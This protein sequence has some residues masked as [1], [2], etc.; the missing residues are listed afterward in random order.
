MWLSINTTP[1][2]FIEKHLI[3]KIKYKT[4]ISS[5]NSWPHEPQ[6]I[7]KSQAKSKDLEESVTHSQFYL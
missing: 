1:Q 3:K 7:K 4:T 6:K 2:F 5:G